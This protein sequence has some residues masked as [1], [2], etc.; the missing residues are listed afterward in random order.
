MTRKDG[1]GTDFYRDLTGLLAPE[2]SL[3]D[4]AC[5][6][7]IFL[8]EAL[9][10]GAGC[11][12]G[13]ELSENGVMGCVSAGLSVY[14]GDITEGLVDYPDRSFDCVSLIRTVDLLAHPEPVLA[15]MLRVG[16]TALLTFTNFG[17]W[18]HR[19]RFALTG[20]TPATAPGCLGGPPARMSYADLRRYCR[21]QRIGIV[22]AAIFPRTAAAKTLPSLF[23]REAAVMLTNNTRRT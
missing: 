6:D 18:R 16:H 2:S 9:R 21:R 20:S 8:R 13:V 22:R 3:L 23:A 14:Q 12:V 7:G 10:A 4:L 1:P 5:G 17:H 19:L 15:E 11:V